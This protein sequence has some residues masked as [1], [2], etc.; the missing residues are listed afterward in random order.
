MSLREFCKRPVVTVSPRNNILEACRLL[1]KHNI[2]CLVAQE[3]GRISGILTDRDIALKVTGGRK[4]PQ[5]T[6][7]GEIMSQNPVR[8]AVDKNIHE[9]TSL[10]HA[11]HVRRVPIVD[12]GDKALGIVTMDDLIALLADEMLDL[13][14]T[15]SEGAQREAA[16]AA[17]GL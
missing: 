9:L 12:G 5:M 13:G 16:Q 3:D 10:M 15:V 14:K 7:V 6:K 11:H 1:E 8:I 17:L 2:G 4:D